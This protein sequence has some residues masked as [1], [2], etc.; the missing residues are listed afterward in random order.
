MPKANK[1]KKSIAKRFAIKR[2][3]KGTKIIKRTC[4]QGHFNARQTGKTKR[5]KRSD[6]VITTKGIAKTILQSVPHL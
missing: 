3:K 5:N 4:G 1:T 2:S 6:T